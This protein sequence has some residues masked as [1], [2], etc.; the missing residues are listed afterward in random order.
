MVGNCQELLSEAGIHGGSGA[1]VGEGARG[2]F[3]SQMLSIRDS[4]LS[5]DSNTPLRMH[6]ASIFGIE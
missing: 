3:P 5:P 6:F 2:I 1:G 4:G